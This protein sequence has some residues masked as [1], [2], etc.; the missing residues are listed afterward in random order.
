MTLTANRHFLT[1]TDAELLFI[2][3]D[4]GASA[5]LFRN[6][7][8]ETKYRAQVTDALNILKARAKKAA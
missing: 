3:K 1:K 2:M 4:A 5:E 8:E 6:Y 7:E